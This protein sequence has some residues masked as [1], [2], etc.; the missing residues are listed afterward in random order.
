MWLVEISRNSKLREPSKP[1]VEIKPASAFA[2][3]GTDIGILSSA[4]HFILK[5]AYVNSCN[6]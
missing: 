4:S 5:H 6:S 1:S 2:L 3:L